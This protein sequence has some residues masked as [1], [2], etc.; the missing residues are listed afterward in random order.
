MTNLPLKCVYMP[1][2]LVVY[3]A[4]NV[5]CVSCLKQTILAMLVNLLYYICCK[6][7]LVSRIV[8]RKKSGTD[9]DRTYKV[10][11]SK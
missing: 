3:N 5:G 9:K 11:L 4:A 7:K 8:T 10:H 2:C 6:A 1:L